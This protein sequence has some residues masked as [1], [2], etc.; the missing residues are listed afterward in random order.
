MAS[1][2]ASP[3][4]EESSLVRQLEYELKATR[5]D[6]QSSIED[7][8]S[9]NEE[10]KASNEEIM[11]M[12][13]ELQ[14]ANEELE[15]SKEELQSLNE[16]LSTV[17]NQ[18]QDKLE[19]LDKSH[20]DMANLLNSSDI[21]TLFLDTQLNIRQ[22]TPSTGKLLGLLKTDIGRP[23][24]TFATDFTGAS[25]L[26]DARQ[27]LD[28]LSQEENILPTS[29]GRH[30][31]RRTLPY[32][33]SDNRIEGLVISFI[34]MTQ[35]FAAEQQ[36]RRM[37]TVLQ[38]SNDAITVFDLQ[39]HFTA[40][41]RGAIRLYGYTEEEAL[42]MN[43]TDIVPPERQDEEQ[44]Y[45][46]RIA[47]N[48]Q[49][50][51]FDSVRIS[52]SGHSL[53]V[54]I[55]VTPLHDESG[56][57]ISVSTTERDLSERLQL[58]SLREVSDRLLHLVEHL[59]VAAVYIENNILQM[60]KAAEQLTGYKRDELSTLDLW[61]DRLF[62]D[63][64]SEIRRQYEQDRSAEFP[65][66]SGPMPLRQQNGDQRFI[67]F[68]GYRYDDHE[69]WILHDVTQHHEYELRILDREQRLRAVMDTAAEAIVVIDVTGS[70]TDFNVAA[71]KL[72]GYSADEVIRR[73]VKLLMPSPYS[74][75]HDGYIANYLKVDK[76]RPRP[77]NMPRELP[78]RHK[79]GH[80]VPLQLT[81]TEIDHQ[82]IFVCNIR[83]LTEQ[84]R[85]ERQIAEISTLE[86]ERI[87]Q[88]IHDGLGQ[89]LTGLSMMAAS[90]KGKLDHPSK[91]NSSLL[92][93]IIKQLQQAIK[94]TRTLSRGLVPVPVTPEGLKD[95]LQ[96]L[97]EDV[98][99][100]MGVDCR[101]DASSTIEIK[102]RTSAMQ[103]YRIAQ[104][105]VNNAIKHAK[106]SHI[107]IHLG[108]GKT[109]C[110]LCI[111]DDGGG[112]NLNKVSPS[113]MGIRIMRYRAGI[114]GCNLEITSAPGKGTSVCCT[115]SSTIINT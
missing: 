95:A 54:W 41:N 30:F 34:D 113:R 17:N 29:D 69:I 105:A 32:R 9:S 51:S 97:A 39:G 79:D 109:F 86:Q 82:G 67:E 7:M 81:V 43:I 107:N 46:Q 47:H 66:K 112:F 21:A 101:L 85:L 77:G 16:E 45:L 8:N 55:T 50:G 96:I 72:F 102:D 83:D 99:N 75:T 87:G 63:Q 49:I 80:I 48:E 1:S 22:F 25:L 24:S 12:N 5:D 98:S 15:T 19:E 62:G 38:D 31:L 13:E 60:N 18:L 93:E 23:I 53:N 14:S 106:P 68:A 42:S 108:A 70:I 84:K 28:K 36:A 6:L 76:P 71:V 78:G 65:R 104:E 61:F 20:N 52:K 74:E 110:E 57:I 90:L 33:T 26:T 2:E 73:N 37:A 11:S 3:P 44:Q 35:R 91:Q 56:R 100:N 94:D 59:P 4:F 114:I 40:W 58:Q 27:V 103:I 10:L 111:S 88:E 89:Q 64:K 115:H 92:N